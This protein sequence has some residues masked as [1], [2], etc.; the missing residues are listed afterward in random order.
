MER[1]GA[2]LGRAGNL[3]SDFSNPENKLAF[4]KYSRMETELDSDVGP[5][6]EPPNSGGQTDRRLGQSA[7]DGPRVVPVSCSAFP[8]GL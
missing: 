8:L 5:S 2:I 3:K 4:R 7:L 1:D 6:D